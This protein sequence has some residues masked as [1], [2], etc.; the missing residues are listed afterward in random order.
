MTSN[1]DF[2]EEERAYLKKVKSALSSLEEYRK[3]VFEAFT[4]IRNMDR[5]GLD[6]MFSDL[7]S[8]PSSQWV[9]LLKEKDELIRATLGEE[10]YRNHPYKER[11][12]VMILVKLG[13]LTFV[14]NQAVLKTRFEE[15]LGEVSPEKK[16]EL[17]REQLR[18]A[19]IAPVV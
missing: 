2:P 11:L 10:Q 13:E 19:G 9:A 1:Q 18:S 7:F 12:D 15:V 5:E 8:H 3:I 4:S 6:K 17:L 16:I 14:R